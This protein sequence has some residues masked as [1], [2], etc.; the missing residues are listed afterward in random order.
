[1]KHKNGH[2]SWLE[3][4]FL[5]NVELD[6][7]KRCLIGILKDITRQ[8]Q[9]EQFLWK[10]LEENVRSL[11]KL[12]K[13]KRNYKHIFK[14]NGTSKKINDNNIKDK[15]PLM[16]NGNNQFITKREKEIL[17]LIANG[18]STK[19]IASKLNISYH[20]VVTHRKNIISKFQ[21]Q[22]TAELITKASNSFWL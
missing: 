8:K 14:Y 22:N 16:V 7:E 18:Y 11:N 20:T 17:Q 21:V 1:M 9:S 2:L 15:F 13:I 3:C 6:G 12:K 19:Q 4:K 10:N 5:K